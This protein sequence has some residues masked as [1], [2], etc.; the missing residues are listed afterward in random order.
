MQDIKVNGDF[1]SKIREEAGITR[2]NVEKDSDYRISVNRLYKIEKEDGTIHPEDIDELAKVY[3]KPELR[4]HYCKCCVLGKQLREVEIKDLGHIAIE[5]INALH[6][7]DV[8]QERLLDIFEDD[9]I[10]PDEYEDFKKIRNYLDKL[11][12]SADNLKLWIDN[13]KLAKEIPEDFE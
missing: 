7:M 4:N 1:L 8:I 3:K 9:K 12:T 5:T 10:T 6:K 13:E 2:E 11:A